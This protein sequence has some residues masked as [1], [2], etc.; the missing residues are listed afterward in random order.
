MNRRISITSLMIILAMIL[1]ACGSATETPTAAPT[2]PP[3]EQPTEAMA[4]PTEVMAEMGSG[5]FFSTQFSPVEEQEKFRAILAG[6]GYDFTASEEGPL[7]DLIL[8]GAQSSAGTV[9]VIGALHGTYPPLAREDAMSNL[10]DLADDLAA[11]RSFA[12][13]FLETGLLGT[14]DY[15]Y[16]IPWMQATYIMAAN[17]DALQYLPNGA[18]TS[19][20]TWDQLASWCQNILDATGSPKCGLPHAGLFHRFLEGYLWP[21]F[22]GGMVSNFRSTDAMEMMT[23]LRDT[24]WPT[25]NPESINYEF[26]QEPLLSGE[27]WVAFDHTARLI[28]AFNSNPDGFVAFPAPAGPAGRGFMPVVVGLGIPA[29]APDP[30]A[31]KAIIEYL[32]RPDVQ[33]A[34]LRDLGFFPVVDGVDFSG[35]PAGVAIEAGAVTAQS[36]AS[37]AL[38]ALLPVGLGER[39]G[40]INQIFRNAFDRVVLDGEDVATVL[41]DEGNNL[42]ALMNETGAPCWAPDPVSDGPCP[43]NAMGAAPEPMMSDAVFFSTQFSPVE[44]QAKFRE[45]LAGGGYDFTA[46]EEGPLIDLILAGAQSGE[47]TVDVIGALHGTYP[48]LAREDAM[49]NLIDVVDDLSSDRE[50]ATA[51]LDTGLLGTNDFLYYVPWMQATYIM[52]ANTQALDYLPDGADLNAL[53]WEQL[54]QWCQN[55]TDGTGGPKCGLPHAGLFHRFLEG[56]LFPSFTG[57]MVT[58]FK[59]SEAADMMAWVRDSLWPNINPE[60]INYEFMQEP[61][62]SGEVWVAFDHTARLIEAFNADPEGYVAFPAPAG[63]AGRG[64]MPV[65]VGLGIPADAPNPDA[66]S[67]VIEYLTRPDVQ[68]QVLNALGFFPVVSGVDFSGLPAGVA[69]EAGAVT[70]QS[71][72]ADALPALLPVGLGERGGEINQIFRNAFDRIV[73]NGEDIETVLA[74]EAANLQ[75]LMNE[76]GAPCWA[77]DPVSD[78]PCQVNE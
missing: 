20:L 71:G 52:A 78:G 56:Y 11:D 59:S 72:S 38:P 42:A 68:E 36:G 63:P 30:E 31:G 7:I 74:E 6:G 34:V 48:P 14:D 61:L 58:N 40:E 53:T 2:Q 75:A 67:S 24:L 21:S 32:T 50:F 17:T 55:L 29:D 9:D 23:W 60:S 45:I 47:G 8:A 73:L 3:V 64:F 41:D 51:F 1:V 54:G 70:A 27:V 65:I 37:D 49:M 5:V 19:N 25:I 43:V 28:E 22:T 13:A 66:G 16:Y 33:E 77:P 44:E 69:I 62:L 18:D 46:S 10:I 12:P 76:T 26:M 57:G 15:L 4:E 39:G 35:L